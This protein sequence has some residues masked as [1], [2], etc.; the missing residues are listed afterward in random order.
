MTSQS[1]RPSATP[2]RPRR[3]GLQARVAALVCL[4]LPAAA[5][6]DGGEVPVDGPTH[7]APGYAAVCAL[8]QEALASVNREGFTAET[9]ARVDELLTA[10]ATLPADHAD[11]VYQAWQVGDVHRGP[12]PELTLEPALTNMVNYCAL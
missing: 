10:V 3:S 5:C 6:T 8:A 11:L 4:A 1:L 9:Y 7:V 12:T 2:S